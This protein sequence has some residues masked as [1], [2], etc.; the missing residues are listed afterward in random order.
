MANRFAIIVV[1]LLFVAA[2]II[3]SQESM[4]YVAYALLAA[5]SAC[6]ITARIFSSL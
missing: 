1:L 5:I 6:V 3:F 4:D 2:M